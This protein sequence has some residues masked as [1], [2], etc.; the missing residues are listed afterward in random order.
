M[1][2]VSK[3]SFDAAALT[4]ITSVSSVTSKAGVGRTFV[5]R[6]KD[7]TAASLLIGYPVIF[8]ARPLT[9]PE[10]DYNPTFLA[11]GS[12]CFRQMHP[13]IAQMLGSNRAKYI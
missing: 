5:V 13:R 11:T 8:P 2:P 10:R 9:L 12:Y 6:V 4:A 3:P 7:R 1:L